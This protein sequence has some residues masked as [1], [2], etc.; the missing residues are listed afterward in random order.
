MWFL[1]FITSHLP[2]DRFHCT[3]VGAGRGCSLGNGVLNDIPLTSNP[4]QEI[5]N[6]KL[7]MLENYKRGCKNTYILQM[8]AL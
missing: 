4:F 7:F 2:P 8:H 5:I 6:F 3:D 1:A